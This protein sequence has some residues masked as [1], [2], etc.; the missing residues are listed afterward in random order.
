MTGPFT[1]EAVQPRRG[2][3]RR[4]D[5]RPIDGAPDDLDTFDG[6]GRVVAGHD[7]T[8]AEA[9][10]DQMIRLLKAGRRAVPEQPGRMRSP[11]S[12]RL[13][14]RR[15]HPN[16]DGEWQP[17]ADAEASR[18]AVVFG[19]QYGP[20]TANQVENAIRTAYTAEL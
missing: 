12:T 3:A 14:G 20:V 13:A 16:A 19:P 11:G 10:L 4:E 6:D 18:V 9:Y 17:E 5:D 1:V 7:P 15:L 2:I 8:N